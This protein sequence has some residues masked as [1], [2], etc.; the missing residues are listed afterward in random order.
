M[1]A[2]TTPN[3]DGQLN[4]LGL[5]LEPCGTDPMT[6]F[7]R[8]GRCWA[9]QQ[10]MG[11]HTICVRLT[12]ALLEFM[13]DHGNDL[14]TPVPEYGF[15]GLQAGDRWCVVAAYWKLAYDEGVI[16]PVYLLRTNLKAL[17]IVP[18]AELKPHALDLS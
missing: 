11:S 6:G 14:I 18:L 1:S 4:V 7:L 9:G 17:D 2:Q 10:D 15:P 16:G 3:D 5:P 12:Q 13:R 8:D